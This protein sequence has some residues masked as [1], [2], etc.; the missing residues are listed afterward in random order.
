MGFAMADA[1]EE[2]I[3]K[4]FLA[5]EVATYARSFTCQGGDKVVLRLTGVRRKPQAWEV[6][7]DYSFDVLGCYGGS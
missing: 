7:G 6:T 3:A 1:F 2:K 4:N 5:T